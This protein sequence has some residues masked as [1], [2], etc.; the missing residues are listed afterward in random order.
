MKKLLLFKQLGL[1]TLL[2]NMSEEG[3]ENTSALF[4]LLVFH[5]KNS[6]LWII[7]V[8]KIY[9]CKIV[10][11]NIFCKFSWNTSNS[12]FGRKNYYSI[13][14]DLMWY[15]FIWKCHSNCRIIHIKIKINESLYWYI[16]CHIIWQSDC[17]IFFICSSSRFIC[18]IHDYTESINQQW[19]VS[20]VRSMDSAIL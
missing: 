10:V 4:I 2:V 12:S 11:R 7:Y 1:L 14:V 6:Q 8:K 20:Q 9:I 18:H 5:S 19:N 17:V 15:V 16:A 3:Y 13:V